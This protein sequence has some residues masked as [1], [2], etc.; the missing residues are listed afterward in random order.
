MV[1]VWGMNGMAHAQAGEMINHAHAAHEV[2]HE[3]AVAHVTHDQL[4]IFAKNF[5]NVVAF[6]V[7]QVV[8]DC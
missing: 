6:T 1:L 2:S 5:V 7:D 4:H 8:N 3:H